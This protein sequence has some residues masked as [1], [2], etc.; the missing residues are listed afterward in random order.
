MMAAPF[1][2][3]CHQ[4]IS[5]ECAWMTYA[6][7][8]Y[9]TGFGVSQALRT[10]LKKMR[11]LGK[12]RPSTARLPPRPRPAPH[13]SCST[14]DGLRGCDTAMMDGDISGKDLASQ[15]AAPKRLNGPIE[16]LSGPKQ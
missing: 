10:R 5:D 8:Q 16:K 9:V 15:Q 1:G 14:Q 6:V 4:R 2:P 7:P 13:L 3:R 11:Y 12:V